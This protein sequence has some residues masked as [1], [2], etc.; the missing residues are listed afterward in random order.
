M[1]WT[2]GY[3]FDNHFPFIRISLN[4]HTHTHT[5]YHQQVIIHCKDIFHFISH[6]PCSFHS[7]TYTQSTLTQAFENIFPSFGILHSSG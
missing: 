7:H 2:L 5:K 6:F 3:R 1:N 4:T